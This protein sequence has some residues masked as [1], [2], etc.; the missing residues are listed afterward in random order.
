MGGAKS[1]SHSHNNPAIGST[2]AT[3]VAHAITVAQI[4]QHNHT[5]RML[6]RGVADTHSTDVA[7]PRFA[8]GPTN[9]SFESWVFTGNTG[10]GNTHN[11]TQ[12]SHTHSLTKTDNTEI[13]ILQPYL[14]VFIYKRVS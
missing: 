12:N 6:T 3:N 5:S 14:T 8:L 13:S 2:I 7:W 11:H 10:S 1:L 4:P 9:S